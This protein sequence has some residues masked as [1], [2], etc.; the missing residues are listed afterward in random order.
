MGR[1]KFT[2]NALNAHSQYFE[3]DRLTILY[4][5]RPDLEFKKKY[6]NPVFWRKITGSQVARGTAGLPSV[7][8]EFNPDHLLMKEK[9]SV[10]PKI[11]VI[12]KTIIITTAAPTMIPMAPPPAGAF[13]I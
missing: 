8:P 9:T 11:S 2:K 6:Q 5:R 10:K 1:N 13:S 12:T 7:I 4:D 3:I